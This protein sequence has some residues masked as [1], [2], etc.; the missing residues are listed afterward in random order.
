MTFELIM[1]EAK[2]LHKI[3]NSKLSK[4]EVLKG[5]SLNIKKN[6]LIGIVGPSGAGKSTLMHLLGGLDLPTKGNVFID[7][8]DIYKLPSDALSALRNRKIGFVFQF[9]HLFAEFSA[10]E[11][12]LLPAIINSKVSI[13]SA[14]QEAKFL[15]ELMGLGRRLT[16]RP[17]EL[18]G[19]EQ[20]RVAIARALINSPEILFCDEPT[21]NLDSEAGRQII[22]MLLT[23]RKEKNMTQVLV[24]HNEEIAKICDKVIHLKD[25]QLKSS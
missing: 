15:L 7:G 21:G 14:R 17:Y 4:L 25:G 20:Q 11:N 3:Y 16:H 22:E 1:I 2:N 12:V 8:V 13:K 24:T 18:S 19:G 10:L 6:D 5:V 23:L 9:Y